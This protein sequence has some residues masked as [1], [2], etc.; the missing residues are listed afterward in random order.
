MKELLTR[1]DFAKA[2]SMDL[3]PD[4]I[5]NIMGMAA[6]VLLSDAFWIWPASVQG[7]DGKTKH[8]G[9]LGGLARHTLEVLVYSLA[10]ASAFI[11]DETL[12]LDLTALIVAAIWHDMGKMDEY[13]VSSNPAGPTGSILSSRNEEAFLLSHIVRG[14]SH[15]AVFARDKGI[16]QKFVDHVTHIIASHHGRREWGSPVVPQTIEA[17]LVHQADML[18]VMTDGGGNPNLRS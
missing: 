17:M 18:S 14:I 1:D 4:V 11:D 7:K 5:D 12:K 9:E 2:M 3:A 6:P 15:W 8:H 10:A 13:T 16:D